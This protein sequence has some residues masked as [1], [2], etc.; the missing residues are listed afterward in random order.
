[1]RAAAS[2]RGSPAARAL[3]VKTLAGNNGHLV[4]LVA[5]AL[6]E[7][8]GA[9][10]D[11]LPGAFARLLEDPIKRDAG[12]RGKVAI[13]RALDRTARRELG[14]FEKGVRHVQH[15]P[16][17]GGRVDT[18]AELRGTC[19]MALVHAGAP[20]AMI[21][22]AVLL[23]DPEV[24]ARIAAARAIAASGDRMVGEP[25][26]RL[27]IAIG[28]AEGE[29]LGECFAALLELAGD[30]ALADVAAYLRHADPAI[31]D[32]AALALGGCRR[33]GVFAL[34]ADADQS[35]VGGAS[36]RVRLLAM[37]LLRDPVA[38]DYLLEIVAHGGDA[39][40]EDAVGALATFR[41]DAMLMARAQAAIARRDDG[42]LCDRLAAL[43]DES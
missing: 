20:Q 29:V 41:H 8:D 27:R 25:L 11:A 34:L 18:A 9:L 31:A 3:L 13:A 17:W 6:E 38:W 26:L 7:G 43:L 15:E 2:D 10:L 33:P 39:A 32:A 5:D 23:A 40:A 35:L 42:K 14:V 36:R 19:G 30:D 4:G 16:V 21:E 37:A 22:A 24:R 1:M 12:C 28:D